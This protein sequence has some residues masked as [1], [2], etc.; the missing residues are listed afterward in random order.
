MVDET[1]TAPLPAIPPPSA[2]VEKLQDDSIKETFESI[3][4][5]FIL[6]FVFRAYVVEAFVIP[7]GSMAPTLMGEHLRIT[8][9][10]CGYHFTVDTPATLPSQPVNGRQLNRDEPYAC[11]MCLYQQPVL[12]DT[13]VSA[14]DRILVHK[15][16][17]SIFE[18]QRWDVVVFRAPHK[19][20]TNFIKRL[21]GL[22]GQ[23]TMIY[24]GNIY[25]NATPKRDGNWQDDEGWLI[26][27]KTDPKENPH[28]IQVQNAVWQPIYHSQYVPLDAGEEKPANR[29]GRWRLPWVAGQRGNAAAWKRSGLPGDDLSTASGY[30]FE[31]D[32]LGEIRF[33]FARMWLQGTAGS[34]PYG[35]KRGAIVIPIEDIR[36]S[37]GFQP[38]QGGLAISLR[39]TARLDDPRGVMRQL[40]AGID[41][42]G[43]VSLTRS[44]QREPIATATVSASVAG[45]T[46]DVEL[47]YVDQ[48]ASVWVDGQRVIFKRFDLAM[49]DLIKRAPPGELIENPNGGEPLRVDTAHIRRLLVPDVAIEVSGSPVTVH[50]VELDRDL[51]YMGG[52]GREMGKS[53]VVPGENGAGPAGSPVFL[54][55]DEFFCLGDNSPFSADSREWNQVDPW[56]LQN[57]FAQGKD[58]YEA[59][60]VVP[61]RLMMGKA[62]FV[63]FPSPVGFSPRK[64]P[65]FPDFG[66][67]RLIH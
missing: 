59:T 11:P 65:M 14:G 62:F 17:Y 30:R 41:A 46:R 47:W 63:Y 58:Y 43:N 52:A 57:A 33:D 4:I 53:T 38:Q 55:E 19:P 29:G 8:C 12:R 67:M 3:V 39:T 66:K 2:P 56:V 44:D 28:A 7:T 36:L 32:Q 48:E 51:H 40:S 16:L 24:E 20:Q 49:P 21:V 13:Y 34:F 35:Q 50:R 23:D 26:A 1:I 18:P 5:A 60:G 22:P 31:S 61:R 15:Y 10:Q 27:R 25:Y 45:R 9:E 6:A 54:A 42:Q 37:A 64:T